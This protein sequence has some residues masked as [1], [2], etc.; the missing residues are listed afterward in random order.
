MEYLEGVDLILLETITLI[1]DGLTAA[2]IEALVATGI[3]VWTSF[4]RCRHGV[5]GVFCQHWGG[6]EGDAFGRAEPRRTARDYVA[7]LLSATERKNCWWL[8]EHA[9]GARPDAMQ[10]LLRTASWDA[11]QV[12]ET[13][14]ALAEAVVDALEPVQKRY[15]EIMAEPGFVAQVLE[16]GAAMAGI[17]VAVLIVPWRRLGPMAGVLPPL[18]YLLVIAFRHHPDYG[19]RAG[20][21]DQHAAAAFERLAVEAVEAPHALLELG[22]ADRVREAHV[23]RRPMAT[24][25]LTTAL[26]SFFRPGRLSFA[27]SSFLVSSFLSFSFFFS[28]HTGVR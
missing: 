15:R 16:N 28:C 9:G 4:R 1:R 5:C 8:A 25:S 13:V 20:G 10:R 11:G 21:A 7:G 24:S 23:R 12:R 18:A 3:P 17:L 26:A 19:L 14:R 27:F 22:P 2:A 6:P